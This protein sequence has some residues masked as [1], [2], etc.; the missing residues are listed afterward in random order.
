M[1]LAIELNLLSA[2]LNGAT[3]REPVATNI[4]TQSSIDGRLINLSSLITQGEYVAAL[5]LAAR[6]SF[7]R[8]EQSVTAPVA[9]VSHVSDDA[10]LRKSSTAYFN[11]MRAASLRQDGPLELLLVAV[12]ALLAFIQANLTGPPVNGLPDSISHLTSDSSDGG[13]G[14]GVSAPVGCT[15]ASDA[16]QW[17]VSQLAANGEE[18]LGR[19]LHPQCLLLALTVL[20]PP[21]GIA[22]GD[23]QAP[24]TPLHGGA[25][26]GSHPEAT[27]TSAGRGG[28]TGGTLPQTWTWWAMR[29]LATHQ[30]IL[31]SRAAS[32]R[33]PLQDLSKQVLDRW[34]GKRSQGPLS[35]SLPD[36]DGR[37][38]SQ[39][40]ALA[41][42][43]VA[44]IEHAYGAVSTA[45]AHLGCA[46]K[47]LQLS[48]SLTGAMGMRT[49][50]QKDAKAQLTVELH[51]GSNCDSGSNTEA[52]AVGVPRCNSGIDCAALDA[53]LEGG[54]GEA[55][56][57]GLGQ[58]SDILQA[59]L[60]TGDD[61]KENG[62]GGSGD[63][64]PTAPTLTSLQQALLLSHAAHI[65][66]GRPSDELAGWEAAPFAEAVLLQHCSQPLLRASARLIMARHERGRSRTRD[67]ALLTLQQLVDSLA[68]PVPQPAQRMRLAF[69]VAHPLGVT[70]RREL[71]EGLIAMGLVGSALPMF[72]ELE[73]WDSLIVCYQMLQ[74]VPQA[75]AIVTA[76]LDATPNEP[77]LW[78]AL[79]D[80]R[81]DDSCY[82][83]AWSRSGG[84][85]ARAK[86]SLARSAMRRKEWAPAVGHWEAALALSPL[87][88]D[89]W[90]ALGY[91]CLK[92]E[93]ET[94]A[95]QAF[96]RAVQQEPDNGDAWANIAAVHLQSHS[97]SSA[98]SAA[99]EAV[100]YKRESWAAWSN[101]ALAA[102]R[103]G[104]SLKALRGAQQVLQLTSGS[105]LE[106][107]VLELLISQLSEALSSPPLGP[108]ADPLTHLEAASPDLLAGGAQSADISQPTRDLGPDVSQQELQ[109]A[110]AA[111]EDDVID[112]VEA[113]SDQGCI[114]ERDDD[115]GDS[116]SEASDSGAA[117]DGKLLTAVFNAR[118]RS[119]LQIGLAQVLKAAAQQPSKDGA[120]WN[121][122]AKF[123]RAT[124][125][126]GSAKEALLK[127][128]RSLQSTPW[129]DDVIAFEALA[130]ATCELASCFVDG[131][132]S[133]DASATRELSSGRLQ[134]R[135][136]INQ[137]KQRF[138]ETPSFRR[139]TDMLSL[140]EDVLQQLKSNQAKG[141][142]E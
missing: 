99:S 71:G 51:K 46:E 126:S 82:E 112:T 9:T 6:E 2:S 128:T 140:T 14:K 52:A 8:T 59:P 135:G 88:P 94:R 87:N 34:A 83:R 30:R 12:A 118:E 77:R 27:A 54:A 133:G 141:M 23:L 55:E 19:I 78:C 43:E 122:L 56:L 136:I 17:G 48:V 100:K 38:L 16:V 129:K 75:E 61:R 40:A 124:G 74:K 119:Q 102:V 68:M 69:A 42:L 20:L 66:K 142:S 72:E 123:Y 18:V 31:A 81:L 115:E 64:D 26:E 90:F 76:R 53:M 44:A 114:H 79:G 117:A 131:G 33:L 95:V 13:S 91:A 110:C 106:V 121:L 39:L 37:Q 96:T 21:L 103:A 134:L 104:Q 89:G 70:L 3:A 28:D 65:R 10:S 73:L 105:Q 63:S 84:R 25:Q 29:A 120:I 130:A 5:R 35:D 67:R 86:R 36:S 62:N 101:Y 41:E 22:V 50:H 7:L 107:E 45:G 113:H 137:T 60:L 80:L 125:E 97:W 93:D 139:L 24:S 1:T 109:V 49:I 98:F 15:A 57:Q 58:D 85:S 111:R 116:F 32:I 108:V 11:A 138:D 47:H 92:A 127:L 132:R 4:G